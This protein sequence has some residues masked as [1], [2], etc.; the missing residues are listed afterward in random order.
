MNLHNCVVPILFWRDAYGER[1]PVNELSD[2]YI[3]NILNR[4]GHTPRTSQ[5]VGEERARML[6]AVHDEAVKRG[7]VHTWG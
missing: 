2:Q 6:S 5:F 4:F 3:R 7:I 1:H